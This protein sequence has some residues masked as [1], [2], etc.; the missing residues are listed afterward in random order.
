MTEEKPV[1]VVEEV[2]E[3]PVLV[4]VDLAQTSDVTVETEA[5]VAEEAIEEIP[6]E[7]ASE[8]EVIE[9]TAE[10]AVEEKPVYQNR[11][12]KKKHRNNG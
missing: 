3:E 6:D 2:A 1:E 8:V 4:S 12:K 7:A 11:N 5:P 9:E 10:E